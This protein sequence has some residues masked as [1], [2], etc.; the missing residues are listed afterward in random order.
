M[1]SAQTARAADRL[2]G[3]GGIAPL[4]FVEQ[5]RHDARP[6]GAQ[7]MTQ[8]NGAAIDVQ[9]VV[10]DAKLPHPDQGHGGEDLSTR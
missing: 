10:A 6:A 2:H 7:G 3:E 4:Q 8:R 9:K 5:R 1:I